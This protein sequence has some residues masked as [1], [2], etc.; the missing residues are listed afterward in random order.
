MRR[1]DEANLSSM[2]TLEKC[3]TEL[4]FYVYFFMLAHTGKTTMKVKVPYG[5]DLLGMNNV[6]MPLNRIV[7]DKSIDVK[8]LARTM[9]FSDTK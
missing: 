9:P 1:S 7:K 3:L 8:Y 6:E 5:N 2:S 4:F